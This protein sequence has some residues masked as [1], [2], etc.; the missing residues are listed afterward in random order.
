MKEKK[1]CKTWLDKL[2]ILP[3]SRWTQSE[4]EL[5]REHTQ[6]CLTCENELANTHLFEKIQDQIPNLEP[7]PGIKKAALKRLRQ[8]KGASPSFLENSVRSILAFFEKPIPVYQAALGA[9]F[10]ILFVIVFNR[11]NMTCNEQKYEAVQRAFIDDSSSV[12]TGGD[13]TLFGTSS[14]DSLI[15]KTLDT[16]QNRMHIEKI[17]SMDTLIL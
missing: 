8:Q 17:D 12:F 13:S 16:L 2:L 15:L 7:D 14:D 5:F 11:V 3:H 9:T 4:K 6:S 10:L 1:G